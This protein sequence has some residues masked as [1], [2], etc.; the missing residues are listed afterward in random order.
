MHW[1]ES[2]RPASWCWTFSK[3]R[4]G[5]LRACLANALSGAGFL[6][7]ILTEAR[8]VSNLQTV[9][10]TKLSNQETVIPWWQIDSCPRELGEFVNLAKSVLSRLIEASNFVCSDIVVMRINTTRWRCDEKKE[11]ATQQVSYRQPSLSFIL[12][13]S[14]KI[15]PLCSMQRV[16]FNL[17]WFLERALCTALI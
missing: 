4:T 14:H 16:A 13:S 9:E 12:L 10:W 6:N 7:S 2:R 17:L 8:K 11:T 3:K 5:Q 15:T 1:L